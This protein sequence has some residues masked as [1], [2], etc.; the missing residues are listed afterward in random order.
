MGKLKKNRFSRSFQEFQ[1]GSQISRSFQEC[2]NP[3]YNNGLSASGFYQ[4]IRFQQI[5]VTETPN[6]N[7]KRKIVWFT[8]PYSLNVDTKIGEKCLQSVDKQFPKVHKFHKL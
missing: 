1:G 4:R 8:P 3:V 6:A 7:R 5:N 2:G